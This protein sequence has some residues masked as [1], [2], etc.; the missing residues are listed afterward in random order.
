MRPRPSSRLLVLDPASR[1]LLFRFFHTRG[2]LAGQDYWATPGGG[3]EPHESFEDAAIREL[4]EETGICITDPGPQVAQRRFVLQLTDGELVEADERFFVVRTND[5]SLRRDG[6]SA[7]EREVMAEH[8]WWS[9]ADLESTRDTVWPQDLVS[10][11]RQ[12]CRINS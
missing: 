7:L 8:R 1:V 6:W 5:P 4:K 12:A 11:L 2:P 9:M 3:V 10:I